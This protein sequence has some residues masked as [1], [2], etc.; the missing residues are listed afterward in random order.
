MTLTLTGPRRRF[1]DR[2]SVLVD[3]ERVRW[4]RDRDQLKY[5]TLRE[6][7]TRKQIDKIHRK[8][9][10]QWSDHFSS[11][12][13]C[14]G[15]VMV[16]KLGKAVIGYQAFEPFA[17]KGN[18][19]PPELP[20]MRF[21]YILVREDEEVQARGLGIGGQLISRAIDL[22]WRRGYEAIYSY[23]TAYELLEEFGFAP[24][25]STGV[26]AEAKQVRDFDPDQAPSLLY[27]I[28]RPTDYWEKEEKW[29]HEW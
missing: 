21:T 11:L 1:M 25:A 29:T 16:C 2:G 7:N 26:V 5:R 15:R 24:K 4:A 22:A 28:E 19:F 8:Q 12:E 14:G 13:K 9:F 17:R 20:A 6:E 27:Y 3:R 18:P 23:V 10:G